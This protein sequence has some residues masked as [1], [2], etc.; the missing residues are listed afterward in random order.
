MTQNEKGKTKDE[1]ANR[2]NPPSLVWSLNYLGNCE[3]NLIRE[4]ENEDY[5]LNRG[6]GNYRVH[7]FNPALVNSPTVSGYLGW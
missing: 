5:R 1:K 6:S 7:N 3:F 4:R 2:R